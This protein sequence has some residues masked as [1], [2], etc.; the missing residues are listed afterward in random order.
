MD[1]AEIR[2]R[3]QFYYE[4]ELQY[5]IARDDEIDLDRCRSRAALRLGN[6]MLGQDVSAVWVG[7]IE[8][9]AKGVERGFEVDF[10]A[11]QLRIGGVLRTHKLRLVPAERAR[12]DDILARASMRDEKL[13]QFQSKRDQ[14]RV[15]EREAVAAMRAKGGNPTL[16][17]VKPEWFA[18][19]PEER[20]S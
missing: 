11:G 15:L 8:A 7:Y 12:E 1:K 4:D 17:E 10:E 20:A 16:I 13:A 19:V 9:I 14:E 2:S 5:A 3:A 6:E 18:A